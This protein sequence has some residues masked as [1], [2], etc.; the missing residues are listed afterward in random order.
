[1]LASIFSMEG[2]FGFG[3]GEDGMDIVMGLEMGDGAGEKKRK[4]A[5][6]QAVDAE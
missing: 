3:D 2:S 4:P 5:R 1:M 6:K